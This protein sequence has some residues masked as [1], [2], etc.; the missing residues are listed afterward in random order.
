M[1]DGADDLRKME[2]PLDI[3]C[4]KPGEM[5]GLKPFIAAPE[6]QA[7]V[8]FP[9]ELLLDFSIYDAA[10]GKRDACMLSLS[11]FSS[12][13]QVLQYPGNGV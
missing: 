10:H 9:G 13:N 5:E 6:H 8:G 3:P 12:P 11:T 7:K 4:L 1:A 2:H